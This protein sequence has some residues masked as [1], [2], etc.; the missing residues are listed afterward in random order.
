[1]PS[2]ELPTQHEEKSVNDRI[3]EKI[4]RGLAT[5]GL[6]SRHVE[7]AP[8]PPALP[9][10]PQEPQEQKINIHVHYTRHH[11]GDDFKHVVARIKN[12]STRPDVHLVESLV[13]TPDAAEHFKEVQAVADGTLRLDDMRTPKPY[14]TSAHGVELAALAK[15]GIGVGN[16]DANSNNPYER[17]IIEQMDALHADFLFDP[18]SATLDEV[19]DSI[20]ANTRESARLHRERERVMVRKF[21]PEIARI[22]EEKPELQSKPELEVLYPLGGIHT[23]FG[24][25]LQKEDGVKV[26]RSFSENPYVWSYDAQLHRTFQWGVEK[27]EEELRELAAKVYMENILRSSLHRNSFAYVAEDAVNEARYCRSII[28]N[29]NQ[30]E[31]EQLFTNRRTNPEALESMLEEKALGV[32]PRTFSELLENLNQR[33][34]L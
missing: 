28:E 13:N 23:T 33:G 25:D 11:R 1:M 6:R 24:H 12:P 2:E 34:I 30:A 19:I 7:S 27:S 10:T 32:L 14:E 16:I 26:T 21:K 17:D 20:L 3:R 31:I 5:I 29:F 18:E 8:P 15:T 9:N 4:R 22:T